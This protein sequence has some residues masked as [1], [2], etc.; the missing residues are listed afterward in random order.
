MNTASP[1]LLDRRVGSKELAAPLLQLNVPFELTTLEFGDVAMMGN[2]PDGVTPLGVERKKVRDLVNSLVS[3]RLV[4]HQLPGLVSNYPYAW[5]VIEGTWR[6]GADGLVELPSGKRQWQTMTPTMRGRDLLAWILT[7]ELRGG[8]KVRQTYDELDTARFVGALHHWWTAK[9]WREHKSHLALYAPVEQALYV[10]PSLTRRWA[11][12]LTGVGFDK[13]VA[14][15]RYFPSA[16]DM[17]VAHESD[18][19]QIDGIGKGIAKRVID[20]IHKRER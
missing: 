8:L 3:G 4:G 12:Q 7:L 18:W 16:F 15:E 9:E 1:I 5:L 14:V 6:E 13:S 19:K 10:K 2:G 20:E 17:V 11:N